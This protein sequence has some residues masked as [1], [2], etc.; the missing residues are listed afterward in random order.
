[1]KEK[2]LKQTLSFFAALLLAFVVV[3]CSETEPSPDKLEVS[4]QITAP[5]LVV[6][7]QVIE[8]I[9]AQEETAPQQV[10][11][12]L[13]D[14]ISL[15]DVISI[16]EP[17]TEIHVVYVE[18]GSMVIQGRE[19][20]LDSFYISRYVLNV[21]LVAK[22]FSWAIERGYER[23]R[24]FP[25]PLPPDWPGADNALVNWLEAIRI[26][27]WLSIMEGLTPVY[28]WG[29]TQE[30][31]L[32]H[33]HLMGFGDI[34]VPGEDGRFIRFFPYM[35]VDWDVDGYRLPTE[36][37]W[38]FAARGGNKSRGYRFAGSDTLADVLTS[39][40]SSSPDIR[41][42][43][44]QKKPN[45]LGIH[46]MSGQSP[47]WVFGPWVEWGE[48]YPPYNPGRIS[49]LDI[50][51]PRHLIQKGGNPL[52]DIRYLGQSLHGPQDRRRFQ[53]YVEGI[54]YD[55]TFERVSVRFV[56]SAGLRQL[57]QGETVNY[58]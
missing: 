12:L 33:A 26:A 25:W 27:N 43:P 58:E 51:E 32:T 14:P 23:S 50:L 39:F 41:Y 53:R 57:S 45:E 54:P 19:I 4:P 2:S 11:T 20:S 36:A 21:Y 3:S 5:P 22:T 52:W 40:E 10:A 8:A 17:I 30:P 16:S 13:N 49:R 56:R 9:E 7:E 1:M 31:I 38:E 48:L 34:P 6:S 44:G 46:D 35:Y 42:I 37:E 47:E 29:D 15:W 24:Q 55:R 18:G 28:L